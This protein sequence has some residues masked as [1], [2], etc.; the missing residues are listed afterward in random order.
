M[1]PHYR[2]NML[3]KTL[4]QAAVAIT[5]L[6]I[7]A[8]GIIA[9]AETT[10]TSTGQYSIVDTN[11]SLCYNS[12]SG[13]STTCS[14]AGY[15]ADYSGNTPSYTAG[16]N[17]VTD[18]ITGLMWTQSSDIDGSGTVDYSDKKYQSDAISYCSNL[19]FGG[20]S[21]WRLP[22]IKESYSLI[23][24][25]GKDASGFSGSDT[26]V[27]TP[28][29][30]SS[31]D[32]AFGDTTSAAGIAAGDRIIDAQYASSTS[33]VSTTMNGN[34]TMFGVNFV[35]GRIKGYPSS[36]KKFY[37]R[38]V[39]GN[40]SY[41]L[42]NFTD[43]NDE[44]ISDSATNLMWQKND[45]SSTDWDNAV[46][47]CEA[48]ITANYT[49]WKLPNAKEL[50]SI[51]DYSRSPDTSSNAAINSVFNSTSFTNE[52]GVTDWGYYWTSTTHAD[53]GSSGTEDSGKNAVYVS[54][55]R[56]LGYFQ[57][58]VMDVHGA[59]AQRSN[60]KVDISTGNSSLNLGNGTFYYKGPQGDILRL[61]NYVRCVRQNSSTSTAPSAPTNYSATASGS[62]V[63]T[64]WTAATGASGYKVYYGTTSGTYLNASTGVDLGNRTSYTFSN[65]PAG[66]YYLAL[67]AYGSSGTLSDYSSEVTVTVSGTTLSAPTNY[68][69][70][71]SG[72][73][74]ATSWTAVAGAS[75]YKVYYGTTSGS[76]LNASTGA[77]LGNRT[78]FTFN[79]VPAGTYYVALK[80]YDSSG[81]LSSYSNEVTVTVP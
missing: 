49:D 65:I 33:Y 3:H 38:C 43:N 60:G 4:I 39:R 80:A 56:A 15:D 22:S 63:A 9:S 53:G 30:D 37:V 75:G 76:Y 81:N 1:K 48:A 8:M 62:S 72:S 19:T 6:G 55:G 20:Y 47:I 57:S 35:D 12:T 69:A 34:A 79:S 66:T 11:Q 42:N 51:V 5:V 41:G 52:Q 74:V 28:F 29:I 36:L 50:Q 77:N 64:S 25:T 16:T 2:R 23:L 54:F 71:V 17:T 7:S 45:T 26:S 13:S 14:G 40:T 68:T 61:N 59:G 32:W 18:N 24:F 10:T 70:T 78:S 31:F 73:S 58:S 46:S 67:K 27:L 44:T 21:D